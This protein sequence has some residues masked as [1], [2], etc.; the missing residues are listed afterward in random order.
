MCGKFHQ[1]IYGFPTRVQHHKPLEVIYKKPLYQVSLC[2]QRMLLRLQKYDLA[3]QYVKRKHLYAADTLSRVHQHA[4]FEDIDSEEIQLAM[5]SL[6]NDL[7]ITE[8]RL[9]DIQQAKMTT[10]SCSAYAN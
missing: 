8:G 10:H 1:Y 9:S 4:A 3:I 2:L 7:P 5:H 6:L